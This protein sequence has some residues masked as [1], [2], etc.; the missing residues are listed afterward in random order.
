MCPVIL[1]IVSLS[2]TPMAT[3]VPKPVLEYIKEAVFQASKD[4]KAKEVQNM[5]FSLP[6]EA[7]D[8]EDVL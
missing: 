3:D 6:K 7:L 2:N 1:H 5:L 8:R 4:G